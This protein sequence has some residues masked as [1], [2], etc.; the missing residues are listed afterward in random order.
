MKQLFI[1]PSYIPVDSSVTLLNAKILDQLEKQGIDSIILTV[2]IDDTKYKITPNLIEIFPS[3]RT[4]Y[5]V[6]SFEI[7]GKILS[8]FRRLL[9]KIFPVFFYAPDYHFIWEILAILKLFQIKKNHKIDIIHSVSAPHCSHVVGLFAKLLFRKPWVC[10]LDDFWVDQPA[11]HYGK[12]R[13]I[14]SWIEKFC[15]NKSDKILSSSKEILELAGKRY[16]LEIRKKFIFI[17]PGY[18]SNDYPKVKLNQNSKYK[19]TYLGVFYKENR[20]PLSIIKALHF[21]KNNHYEIYKKIEFK[22]IGLKEQKYEIEICRLDLNNVSFIDRVDY[23]E[24]MRQ[25]KLATILVHIGYISDRFKNDIHISG[26]IFEYFGA[27]R[28]ILGVTTPLGPVSDIIKNNNGIV[29]DYNNHFDI[30]KK[31]VAIVNKYKISDLYNWENPPEIKDKYDINSV[32]SNYKKLFY[33]LINN[34]ENCV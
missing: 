33:S 24:S 25:M 5:R 32:S 28:L 4:V 23:W 21:I 31:I 34:K 11:E 12:Y 1:S 14:N 13:Y 10:H 27:E 20:E 19:F 8:I 22:F 6:R 9:N 15:F 18:N 7:G 26:K 29:C 17:P 30:A 16:S 2:S 3:N